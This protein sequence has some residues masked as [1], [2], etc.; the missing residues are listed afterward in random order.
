VGSKPQKLVSAKELVN[1]Y[2]DICDQ[3]LVDNNLN[4]NNKYLFFSSLE[5]SIDQ[6]AIN[7]HTELNLNISNFND[8]N[9]Y[10]K[11]KLLSNEAALANI[12]KREISDDGF[13]S[14][15]LI[16]KDKLLIP[17]DTSIITSNDP[18][19]LKKLNSILDKY[20]SFILLLRKT[21]EEC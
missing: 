12:I 17:I 2:I 5:Q 3:I 8:F 6:F 13:L 14:D 4:Q 20:K 1:L 7:L 15:I 19:N 10:A 21:L 16:A 18:I 9:F 11:W